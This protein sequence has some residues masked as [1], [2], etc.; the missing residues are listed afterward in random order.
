MTKHP[1]DP[2]NLAAEDAAA[3]QTI[4]IATEGSAPEEHARKIVELLRTAAGVKAVDPE[5]GS[6]RVLVAFDSRLT[7]PARLHEII[8]RSDYRPS[9]TAVDLANE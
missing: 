5:A 9:S 7:N 2:H 3:L 6:A 8:E 1:A 4:L